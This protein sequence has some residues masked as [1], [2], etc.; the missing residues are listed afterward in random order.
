[1]TKAADSSEH[2]HLPIQL[3]G[4]TSQRAI[5]L[6]FLATTT[7]NHTQQYSLVANN[8]M[9]SILAPNKANKK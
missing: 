9:V 4:L 7:S 5:I 3:Q 1:M 2:W 8:L 6:M